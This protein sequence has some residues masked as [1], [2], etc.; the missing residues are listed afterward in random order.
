M[1]STYRVVL[2]QRRDEPPSWTVM[3]EG[4][5]YSYQSHPRYPTEE[6]AKAMKARWEKADL[7]IDPVK[8]S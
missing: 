3:R 6:E 7:R 4:G 8:S 5:P 1:T 2:V